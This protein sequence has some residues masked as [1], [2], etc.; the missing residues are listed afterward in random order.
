MSDMDIYIREVRRHWRPRHIR[1]RLGLS[2]FC[3]ASARPNY[4]F[5]FHISR[6][7][8]ANWRSAG[9]WIA[10]RHH[11]TAGFGWYNLQDDAAAD[12]ITR[13]L[14]DNLSLTKPSYYAYKR[15]R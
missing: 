6:L 10:D 12:R 5:A 14:L 2:E 4:E 1:P 15:A 9:A 8:Q 3:V 13:G 7:R 11:Y